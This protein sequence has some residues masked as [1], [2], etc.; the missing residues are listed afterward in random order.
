MTGFEP[1]TFWSQTRRAT[2]CATSRKCVITIADY[3]N[4]FKCY[5]NKFYIFY[6]K[7]DPWQNRT[8]D[9]LLRRQVLYPA[10]LKGRYR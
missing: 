6:K 3:I 9:N 5:T 1:A 7:N 10:E 8:V 2:N 4:Y